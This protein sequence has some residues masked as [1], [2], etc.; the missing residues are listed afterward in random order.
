VASKN[1]V[2]LAHTS[3]W[4]IISLLAVEGILATEVLKLLLA[5]LL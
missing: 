3:T 5:V 4:S 2:V 1:T